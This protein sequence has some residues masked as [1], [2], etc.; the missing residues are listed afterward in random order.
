MFLLTI[1]LVCKASLDFP[2]ILSLLY[3]EQSE[4]SFII[5]FANMSGTIFQSFPRFDVK[6]RDHE[7]SS[8]LSDTMVQRKSPTYCHYRTVRIFTLTSSMLW[9]GI[10]SSPR[11]G[12]RKYCLFIILSCRTIFRPCSPQ[13]SPIVLGHCSRIQRREKLPCF[14]PFD[15]MRSCYNAIIPKNKR[16]MF[17]CSKTDLVLQI[18]FV[19]HEQLHYPQWINKD[20]SSSVVLDELFNCPTPNLLTNTLIFYCSGTSILLFSICVF[21]SDRSLPIVSFLHHT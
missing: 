16:P 21:K 4:F 6:I 12:P 11:L 20:C 5:V 2:F 8:F 14:D 15:I 7:R 17:F 19:S 1:A 10:R 3:R 13:P 18:L 9:S